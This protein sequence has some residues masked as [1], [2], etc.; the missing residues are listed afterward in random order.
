MRVGIPTEIKHNEHRVA[1]TQP[2]VF[3]LK[4][5]GHEVLVQ[6]GAGLGSAITD[7]G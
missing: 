4:R 7:A 2:G 1:I 3:E 5:R 6:S